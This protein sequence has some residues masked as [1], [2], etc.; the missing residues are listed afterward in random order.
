MAPR[1]KATMQRLV[2]KRDDAYNSLVLNQE[3]PN[4]AGLM[5]DQT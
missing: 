4:V 3:Y 5:M 2:K 1:N